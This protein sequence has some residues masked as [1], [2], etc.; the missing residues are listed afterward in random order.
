MTLFYIYLWQLYLLLNVV[1]VIEMWAPSSIT[2][3]PNGGP[4]VLGV[5]GA[6]AAPKTREPW[7]CW[8]CARWAWGS[9]SVLP[10]ESQNP[11]MAGVWRALCGSPS[12]TLCPSRVT[13]SRLH[14]TTSRWVWNISREGDSTASLGSLGQGSVSLRGKK[15]FLMFRRKTSKQELVCVVEGREV[16]LELGSAV[17]RAGVSNWLCAGGTLTM[18]SWASADGADLL[19][20][21]V[22]GRALA[23]VEAGDLCLKSVLKRVWCHSWVCH[24]YRNCGWCVHVHFWQVYVG[25]GILKCIYG[26]TKHCQRCSW[27]TTEK[28]ERWFHSGSV[29]FGGVIGM[30]LPSRSTAD[31]PWNAALPL[32]ARWLGGVQARSEAFMHQ[33]RLRVFCVEQSPSVLHCDMVFICSSERF[34][35]SSP[36]SYEH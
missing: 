4:A 6:P 34:L 29:V 36:L 28:G 30:S 17:R 27:I 8:L 19:L 2:L 33:R 25:A 23:C 14:S 24:L 12:P 15:F 13:Q 31:L 11:S 20:G 10:T 16:N 9:P 1:E 32:R 7:P 5:V 22:V 21:C 18:C 35:C 26:K 3:Q